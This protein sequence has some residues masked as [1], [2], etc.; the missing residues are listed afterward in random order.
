MGWAAGTGPKFSPAPDPLRDLGQPLLPL[1]RGQKLASSLGGPLCQIPSCGGSP[2]RDCAWGLEQPQQ[3]SYWGPLGAKGSRDLRSDHRAVSA[4]RTLFHLPASGG[5][6][7]DQG[8][9][10][11]GNPCPVQT[12]CLWAVLRQGELTE[13]WPSYPPAPTVMGKY[14]LPSFC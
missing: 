7:M 5:T 12:S 10:S 3:S 4:V 2:F 1:P 6:L 8:A 9:L 13:E 14:P 11:A